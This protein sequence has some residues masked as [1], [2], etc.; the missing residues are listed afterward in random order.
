MELCKAFNAQTQSM[1]PGTPLPVIITA[2]ADRTFSFVMKMPPVSYLLKKAAG[3]TKGAS[4]V[5]REK[6]GKVTMAQIREI[7]EKKMKD[8]NA[9]DV[10]AACMMVIGSAKS[11][12]LEVV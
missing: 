8:L 5:G 4:M 1:E 6:S 2:Y 10:D 7:A 11:M 12:G 9:N 3:I